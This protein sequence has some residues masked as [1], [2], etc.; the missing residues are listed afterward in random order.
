VTETVGREHAR[1]LE[2]EHRTLQIAGAEFPPERLKETPAG[3]K[4]SNPA[5]IQGIDAHD[6]YHTGLI[7]FLKRVLSGG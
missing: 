7:P 2:A 3:S 1:L 4:I 6:A 5:L